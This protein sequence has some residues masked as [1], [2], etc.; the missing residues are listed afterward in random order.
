M[1][2]TAMVLA[3]VEMLADRGVLEGN[4]KDLLGE[5]GEAH[6]GYPAFAAR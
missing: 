4:V 6:A 5:A 1:R 2:R 3:L